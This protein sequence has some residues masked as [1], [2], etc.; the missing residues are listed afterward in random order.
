MSGDLHQGVRLETGLT[1]TDILFPLVTL[2]VIAVA[3]VMLFQRMFGAGGEGQTAVVGKIYYKDRVAERKFA[4][5]ALWSGLESGA[6]V[7]NYD[8]IRTETKAEAIIEL[9]DGT[10][11]EMDQ[12]TMIVIVITDQAA[13][14]N[15]ARGGIRTVRDKSAAAG[16][17]SIKSDDGVVDLNNG[18]VALNKTE[19]EDL[20][21]TLKSGEASVMADGR[22]E[23]LEENQQAQV[24]EE[25][26]LR[27]LIVLEAPAAN[28]RSFAKGGGINFRWGDAGGPVEFEIA[29]DRGFST[30]VRRQNITGNATSLALGD[31]VYYWRVVQSAG[32][33]PRRSETRRLTVARSNPPRLFS[34]GNGQSI[35]VQDGAAPVTFAWEQARFASGYRLLIGKSADL[36]DA[37]EIGTTTTSLL[38]RIEEGEYYWKIVT[39]SSEADAVTESVVSKFSVRRTQELEPPRP[40]APKDG[41]ELN[42]AVISR[43]GVTLNWLASRGLKDFQLQIAQDREFQNVLVDR[44]SGSNFFRWQ[45]GDQL[46]SGTYFWRV[47]ASATSFSGPQRFVV[48]DVTKIPVTAPEADA[49]VDLATATRPG[50]GFGWRK[51]GFA[52]TYRVTVAQDQALRNGARSEISNRLSANMAGL[53]PGKY[54]WKVELLDQNNQAIT[55]SDVQSFVIGNLLP[56]P[57]MTAPGQGAVVNMGDRESLDFIWEASRG[58]GKY[59]YEFVS[60]DGGGKTLAS[61]SQAG[62][63]FSFRDLPELREGLYEWRL[64]ALAGQ[65]AD[66]RRSRTVATRFRIR[67]PRIDKPKFTTGQDEFYLPPPDQAPAKNDSNE[68]GGGP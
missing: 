23:S 58:A 39:N 46:Q 42:R 28:A 37:R 34:P 63:R 38:Q 56:E 50:V 31:G 40:L 1:R 62:T 4:K 10:R 43:N 30:N 13:E 27:S 19:G 15:F 33:N 59:E 3:S 49:L 48:G 9:K 17:F 51:V 55:A 29:S 53:E 57:R 14:I 61:G 25:L 16:A 67:L 68:A 45:A 6:P 52:G 65:G 35:A 11:I 26:N 54:F 12:N 22:T 60:I 44:Q 64:S 32:P 2:V 66:A 24:G 8:T 47:R 21:V 5:Q 41:E 18:D 20:T 36:N 7:Y